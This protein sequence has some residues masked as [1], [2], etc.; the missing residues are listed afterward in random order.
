MTTKLLKLPI[1]KTA[2]GK[3]NIL[4]LMGWYRKSWSEMNVNLAKFYH[5]ANQ[6]LQQ[7][8]SK[9]NI[10]NDREL[11]VGNILVFIKLEQTN[12]YNL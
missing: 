10:K 4:I 11:I 8:F 3:N 2:I 7:A 9:L 5:N 6:A 12:K 1:L